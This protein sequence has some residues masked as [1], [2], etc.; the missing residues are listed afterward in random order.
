[1]AGEGAGHED[2][3]IPTIRVERRL[4]RGREGVEAAGTGSRS[5]LARCRVD[6]LMT[7]MGLRGAVRTR[8][9]KITTIS[10]ENAARPLSG[11]ERAARYSNQP[12]MSWYCLT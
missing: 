3:D 6:R 8:A 7:D 5:P 4:R 10:D 1:M 11:G 2:E 9:F 12:R